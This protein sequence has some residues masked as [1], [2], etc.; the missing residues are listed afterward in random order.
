MFSRHSKRGTEWIALAAIFIL[1]FTLRL[2]N[3]GA[4][5]YW[6]DE[7][8]SLDISTH[9]QS[10]TEMVRYIG[11]VEFHPPLYYVIIRS[12]TSWFGISELATRLPSLFFGMGVM[13]VTYAMGR[14]FFGVTAALV[15]TFAI[16]ISPMQIEFSQEARPYAMVCF[17]GALSAFLVWEYLR[18]RRKIHLILYAVASILGLYLNYSYFFIIFATAGWW[19]MESAFAE[20][21]QRGKMVQSWLIAHALVFLGYFPWIDRLLAKIF[22]S[23]FS[24]YDLKHTSVSGRPVGFFGEVID[25]LI[26]TTKTS[27][28]LNIQLFAQLLFGLLF[29]ALLTVAVSRLLAQGKKKYEMSLRA[30]IF[31]VWLAAFPL[32]LFLFSPMSVPY[33][34]LYVR[35]VIFITIPLA[36]LLGFVASSVSKKQAAVLVSLFAI[37][38]IPYVSNIVDNDAKLDHYHRIGEVGEYIREHYRT[39]DIVIVAHTSARSNLAHFLPSNI[40]VDALLPLVY[41]SNDI[42]RSRATLGLLEIESQ[43]RRSNIYAKFSVVGGASAFTKLGMA[44]EGTFSKGVQD[45]LSRLNERYEPARVWLYGFGPG[46]SVV[47]EWFINRGWRHAF[48]A[49]PGVFKLDLYSS[50]N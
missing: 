4:E 49:I 6:G 20:K 36:L 22:L 17:F 18:R 13:G 35:H 46:D 45:K 5:P 40:A 15:A 38:L 12:W 41:F 10:L 27:G 3:I 19:A 39:G 9:F 16:A 43:I 8:L 29:F 34:P 11:E 26:W 47:H 28:V 1:G 2:I 48:S 37:S 14:R 30:L 44:R 25:R 31:M 21:G 33:S 23:Q 42:W 32:V 24:F 50:Q 7:I